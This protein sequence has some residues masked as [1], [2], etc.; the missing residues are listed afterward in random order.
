[1]SVTRLGRLKK[2]YTKSTRI[3]CSVSAQGLVVGRDHEPC[4][5]GALR[6]RGPVSLVST[7]LAILIRHNDDMALTAEPNAMR[8]DAVSPFICGPFRSI[9]IDIPPKHRL[10]YRRMSGLSPV[11]GEK[12]DL[13]FV[14]ERCRSVSYTSS[15]WWLPGRSYYAWPVKDNGSEASSH[16]KV[17]WVTV[18]AKLCMVCRNVLRA[19]GPLEDS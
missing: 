3:E 1:M 8:Y 12:L 9:A 16:G 13:G 14:C 2:I 19:V 7:C 11:L 10:C 18:V 15:P 5:N 17:I 6:R 4:P